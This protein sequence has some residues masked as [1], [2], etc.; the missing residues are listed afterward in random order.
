MT[1]FLD[2]T[3]VREELLLAYRSRR[4]DGFQA[5]LLRAITDPIRPR[6][7]EAKWRPHPILVAVGVA[8]VISAAAFFYF[9]V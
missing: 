5:M 6:T 7:R 3:R 4:G 1:S 9:S 8:F 2:G